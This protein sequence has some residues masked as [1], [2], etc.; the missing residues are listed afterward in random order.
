MRWVCR[1][2]ECAVSGKPTAVCGGIN[3]A[4]HVTTRGAGGG[5]EQIVPLCAIHHEEGH[6]SGWETFE[7]RYNVDLAQMAADLWRSDVYHRAKWE[8]SIREQA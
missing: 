4:H 1:Q 3:H 7:R 8:Q 6:R 2:F 5:D